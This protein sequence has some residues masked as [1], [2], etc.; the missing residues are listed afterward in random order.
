MSVCDIVSVRFGSFE[1]FLVGLTERLDHEGYEH[2]IVFRGSPIKSVELA[3]IDAGAK[4]EVMKPHKFQIVNLFKV[5]KLVK[6]FN[7]D[8]LHL[9]FYP[10][11]TPLNCLKLFYDTKIVYTGHMGGKKAKSQLRLFLRKIYYSSMSFLFDGGIDKVVCVSKYVK[12]SYFRDYGIKTKRA[13]VIYNGINL[14]KYSKKQNIE[15]IKGNY[16]LTDEFIITCV[17]LRKDKGAYFLVKA[18]PKI[19]EH[20]KNAKFVL[21]GS[22]ECKDYLIQEIVNLKLDKYF[23]FTGLVPDISE[24]YSISSCVVMPSVF[25]EACPFTAIE[26]MACGCPVIAFDS[27]GTKEVVSDQV[28]YIT[29]KNVDALVDSILSFYFNDEYNQMSACGIEIVNTKF[30]I[31]TCL[32]KYITLYMSLVK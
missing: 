24:I 15:E 2:I 18:A 8:L 30:S 29:E 10:I 22:G 7:P 16:G 1:E 12:D 23:I 31:D 26:S 11:H 28:G 14:H 17:S 21:V 4:I 27:G 19:I 32:H 20:V 6:K 25:E 9:H 3:L 13:C 5:R